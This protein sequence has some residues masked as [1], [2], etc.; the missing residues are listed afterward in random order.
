MSSGCTVTGHSDMDTARWGFGRGHGHWV[1][2]H[3][4]KPG[5]DVGG[6][7]VEKETDEAGP[8]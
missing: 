1:H 2:R 3:R 5:Y 7:K 4:G 6:G 8:N